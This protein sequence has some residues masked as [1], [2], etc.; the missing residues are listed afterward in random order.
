MP[1]QTLGQ[2]KQLPQ[3]SKMSPRGRYCLCWKTWL[4]LNS[5]EF[6]IP[7]KVLTLAF[8]A[9]YAN[10]SILSESG[11]RCSQKKINHLNSVLQFLVC[12][13]LIFRIGS[14]FGIWKRTSTLKLIILKFSESW[15]SSK[16]YNVIIEFVLIFLREREIILLVGAILLVYNTK[17]L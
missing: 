5:P 10:I 17:S 1:P 14:L 2:L 16:F 7:K 8:F 13:N 4:N 11:L 12:L 6:I 3:I 9:V 15:P